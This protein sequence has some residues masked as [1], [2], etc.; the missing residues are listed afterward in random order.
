MNR[1]FL[2][3]P[4]SL[5]T[6]IA[7][8]P[9]ASSQ[10]PWSCNLAFV[11]DFSGT[12]ARSNWEAAYGPTLGP[13]R[14]TAVGT[15]DTYSPTPT[16]ADGYTFGFTSGF[17][18]IF[19]VAQIDDEVFHFAAN[20]A[21]HQAEFTDMLGQGIRS[22]ANLRFALDVPGPGEYSVILYLGKPFDGDDPSVDPDYRLAVQLVDGATTEPFYD[23]GDIPRL[24]QEK[25]GYRFSK[26][27]F[28]RV[29]RVVDVPSTAG[30][31]QIELQFDN[32]GPGGSGTPILGMSV[33][34][35]TSGE[36][37][38]IEETPTSTR[39]VASTGDAALD[40]DLQRLLDVLNSTGVRNSGLQRRVF[41]FLQSSYDAARSQ[42]P[43]DEIAMRAYLLG[44]CWWLG[45]LR[46]DEDY[47]WKADNAPETERSLWTSVRD[48][49]AD[50]LSLFPDDPWV[51]AAAQDIRYYADGVR[52]THARGYTKPN[53]IAGP[54]FPYP[55]PPRL[56]YDPDDSRLAEIVVNL[57]AGK[58]SLEQ[59]GGNTLG[60]H[61]S[62]TGRV[63]FPAS[64]FSAK[65]I[66]WIVRGDFGRNPGLGRRSQG[67]PVWED[68]NELYMQRLD[69]LWA[70]LDPADDSNRLFHSAHN[71][72]MLAWYL[73]TGRIEIAPGVYEG[74]RP[75]NDTNFP[76][77]PPGNY[78]KSWW[79]PWLGLPEMARSDAVTEEWARTQTLLRST[80]DVLLQWYVR[81]R[82]FHRPTPTSFS[83]T[84][85][86]G[87]TDDIELFNVAGLPL[88]P[89]IED[90]FDVGPFR[91]AVKEALAVSVF[92]ERSD[93][94][95]YHGY[96][97]PAP[98]TSPGDPQ[99]PADQY[100]IPDVEH[101]S[102][103]GALV[104]GKLMRF[105][106]GDPDILLQAFRCMRNLDET[107][108]PHAISG[109]PD[110]GVDWTEVV[111]PGTPIPYRQFRSSHFDAR[112]LSTVSSDG[113]RVGNFTMKALVPVFALQQYMRHP[114]A[115]QYLSELGA[116]WSR[117]MASAGID[118]AG[119]PSPNAMSQPNKPAGALPA[120][121]DLGT[122]T[123]HFGSGTEWW[124][125][126]ESAVGKFNNFSADIYSVVSLYLDSIPQ[127]HP[128]ELA[129]LDA[130]FSFIQ[131]IHSTTS[132]TGTTA[133]FDGGSPGSPGFAAE[134]MG[135]PFLQFARRHEARLR[136][137]HGATVL[138]SG[139]TGNDV[140]DDVFSY[141][142]SQSSEYFGIRGL[143]PVQPA[144]PKDLTEISARFESASVL[145]QD[146]F[147]LVSEFVVYTDRVLP[148]DAPAIIMLN[149]AMGGAQTPSATIESGS[150]AWYDDS[151][152][153]SLDMRDC[154][155]L[156]T[157]LNA[158]AQ[159]PAAPALKAL[160]HVR[161][162]GS[163]GTVDIGFQLFGGVPAG[164]YTVSCAIESTPQ[165]GSTTSI[166]VAPF[167]FEGSAVQVPLSGLM[168]GE[169]YVLDLHW[170]APSG[171]PTPSSQSVDLALLSSRLRASSATGVI[172]VPYSN[173]GAS[174]F[175]QPVP[176][177]DQM[178]IRI[179]DAAGV[180]VC[181]E[182]A[183]ASP[184][185]GTGDLQ[186][187]YDAAS[188]SATGLVPG[189]ALFVKIVR[190]SS[191]LA[192]LEEVTTVNNFA[193]V[194]VQ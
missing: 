39:L 17:P 158:A 52:Y 37:V 18:G 78:D 176:L 65:A 36:P 150:I 147:P 103:P 91:R 187:G 46:G 118:R 93:H 159:L 82:L 128:D 14:F 87:L 107:G 43:P 190:Q 120:M 163:G 181:P 137:L 138:G 33:F 173:F 1:L 117:V 177:G 184:V 123:G 21:A 178:V 194:I 53:E 174:D 31:T 62:P 40:V 100:Q 136:A 76:G 81:R 4:G 148:N 192:D 144:P 32:S 86:G 110:R 2:T 112:Q 15:D 170:T 167:T 75:Y 116:E 8:A 20:E 60:V 66:A 71:A 9:L 54:A 50:F 99:P 10:S 85:G 90:E 101:A 19:S 140:M 74:M 84:L 165:I 13:R 151:S 156:V 146:V 23:I 149:H 56:D 27:S 98:N 193:R 183:L 104:L 29:H 127:G 153:G 143:P 69:G 47:G 72:R 51:T 45:W 83:G 35:V 3:L 38:V 28:R 49:I 59:I 131:D 162:D 5:A 12:S 61:P 25:L 111:D 152:D 119:T 94:N 157:E 92:D 185:T 105:R 141:R 161:D 121:Y 6:F 80:V 126:Q 171:S 129:V 122:P 42:S 125:D 77:G 160:I 97:D 41:A 22:H 139:A 63:R 168:R 166:P 113:E 64:P 191:G 133:T 89:I 106:F 57:S 55:N 175:V 109:L 155:F 135:V 11:A 114:K 186:P 68:W 16:S 70:H 7:L 182:V 95:S 169:T 142:Y 124:A 58:A 179:E 154:S 188:C 102:E 180:L 73:V 44:A 48:D 26:Y 24:E 164:D 108:N 30:P 34:R 134:A 96:W 115:E 88:V 67:V 132:V 145:W 189:Q 130:A 172:E 79:E